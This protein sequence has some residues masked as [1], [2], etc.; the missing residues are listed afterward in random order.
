[1]KGDGANRFVLGYPVE[2]SN[3]LEESVTTLEKLRDLFETNDE[4]AIRA[5]LTDNQ[6]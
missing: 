5:L 1:M 4:P 6:S 3:A 2:L